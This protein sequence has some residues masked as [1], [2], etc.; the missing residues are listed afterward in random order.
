MWKYSAIND[1]N[2]ISLHDSSAVNA[3]IENN[4]ITLTFE[5][6]F[7][8]LKTNNKNPY[9]KTLRT[10]QSQ[11]LFHKIGFSFSNIYL[12]KE[13]EVFRKKIYTRRIKI[14][15]EEF[16]R[17]ID[18]GEWEFE[19]VDEAYGY[20]RAVFDGFVYTKNRH[21]STECQITLSYKEMIYS[22]NEI[23]EDRPF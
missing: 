10:D 3:S 11:I 20:N 13:L 17:K 8:I 9:K 23:R 22:W 18:S 5:D 19:F 14:S 21:Y 12:F 4:D 7:W 15:F 6:G 2:N 1:Y 16:C